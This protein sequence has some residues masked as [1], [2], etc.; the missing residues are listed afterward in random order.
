MIANNIASAAAM[1]ITATIKKSAQALKACAGKKASIWSRYRS[2][3]SQQLSQTLNQPLRHDFTHDRSQQQGGLQS[4]ATVSISDGRSRGPSSTG[5]LLVQI[6]GSAQIRDGEGWNSESSLQV[7]DA[8]GQLRLHSNHHGHKHCILILPADGLFGELQRAV[9]KHRELK[10]AEQHADVEL[11]AIDGDLTHLLRQIQKID[12]QIMEVGRLSNPEDE[13][14]LCELRSGLASLRRG[15]ARVQ[16]VQEDF[17]RGMN[18]RYAEHRQDQ[19][20][21]F[22]NLDALLVQAA[23]LP[24]QHSRDEHFDQVEGAVAKTIAQHPASVVFRHPGIATDQ[25]TQDTHQTLRRRSRV[26]D[27]KLTDGVHSYSTA[28]EAD[29]VVK[30]TQKLLYDYHTKRD[31]LIQAEGELEYRHEAFERQ[32]DDRDERFAAGERVETCT[33]FELQQLQ[34]TQRMTR[35]IIEAEQAFEGVKEAAVAAGIQL[36]GSDIQSGFVDDADDGYRTSLEE[37]LCH[38]IDRVRI[39]RWLREV[40]DRDSSGRGDPEESK[41]RE[42]D[43]DDWDARTVQISDTA[44]M[45]AEGRAKRRIEKWQATCAKINMH[46][47][48]GSA[49]AVDIADHARCG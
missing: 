18:E 41:D 25:K 34:Q 10:I 6:D 8:Y 29:D 17:D 31:N 9:L 36:P 23:A 15:L 27:L 33:E 3:K 35:R 16:E 26:H 22:D 43:V 13:E 45:V 21:I 19:C 1:G 44:S 30:H 38:D 49:T 2:R 24:Q 4:P 32:A 20:E 12:V 47:I 14:Q 7:D 48:T 40:P 11:D 39:S 28:A 5:H 42:I 37:R 46:S